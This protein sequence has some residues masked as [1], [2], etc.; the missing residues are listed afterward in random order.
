[1]SFRLVDELEEDVVDGATNEGSQIEEFAVNSVESRLEE[2][3]LPRI[4]AVE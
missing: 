4:L 2:I 1:M 3:S